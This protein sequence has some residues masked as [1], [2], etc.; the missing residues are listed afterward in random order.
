LDA[1]G[2]EPCRMHVLVGE[3]ARL[4][5]EVVDAAGDALFLVLRPGLPD[6]ARLAGDAL[7]KA[8]QRLDAFGAPRAGIRKIE[9]QNDRHRSLHKAA[10][11]WRPPYPAATRPINRR[12][13]RRA[14]PRCGCG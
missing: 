5:L 7:G 13:C 2:G 8:P 11:C 12:S 14:R 1:E 9:L 6:E 4:V 10:V 3:R